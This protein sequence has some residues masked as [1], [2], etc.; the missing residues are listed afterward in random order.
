MR[1]VVDTNV[2]VSGVFFSG[3]PYRI[4]DAWRSGKIT[5]VASPEILDEYSRTARE[6]AIKFHEANLTP[7]LQLV[8]ARA[9]VVETSPLSEWV[10]SDPDDDE[11]LACAA[12]AKTK[13][14]VTGDK[15]LLRASGWRGVAVLKPREF[16]EQY[17]EPRIRDG[18][19][20]RRNSPRTRR[21]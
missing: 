5:L 2:F 20:R 15:A 11:F 7:W 1:I 8:A 16:I 13:L 12:A 9:V 19:G 3:P 6:L 18:T 10:C 4:L 21:T 14:V 17:I